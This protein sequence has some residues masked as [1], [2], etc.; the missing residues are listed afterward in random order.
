M[1]KIIVNYFAKNQKKEILTHLEKNIYNEVIFFAKSI[2]NFT[3]SL[4]MKL[5]MHIYSISVHMYII[6]IFT[7][8]Q[9]VDLYSSV[10]PPRAAK[11][12]SGWGNEISIFLFEYTA[13]ETFF[14]F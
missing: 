11:D 14:A 7:I 9:L 3:F 12:V 1:F 2:N 8:N 4:R 13:F 5:Y 6:S 10:C